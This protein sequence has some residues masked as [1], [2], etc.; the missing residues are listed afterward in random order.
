MKLH[1]PKKPCAECPWRRDVA[2]GQFTADRYRALASTGED[3]AMTLFACHKS[4][5]ERPFTC[6]GFLLRGGAHNLT[7]RL[8]YARGEIV[9]ESVSDGGYPLYRDYR[10]MAVANG[11]DPLDPALARVRSR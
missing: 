11:V 1:H 2:A 9:P 5:D 8:A 3:M 7:L 6:A 4:P 10:E